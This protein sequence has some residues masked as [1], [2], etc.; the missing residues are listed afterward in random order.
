[1][2]T[3][4]IESLAY[5]RV[6][7]Q[8]LDALTDARRRDVDALVEANRILTEGLG[9]LVRKQLKVRENA[10][11]DVEALVSSVTSGGL[12][13]YIGHQPKVAE[14]WCVKAMMGSRDVAD[15][16]RKLHADACATIYDR[17]VQNLQSMR[18]QARP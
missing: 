14:F 17:F 16:T 15:M 11:S 1:M 12:W 18:T 4:V 2:E 5:A 9:H 8:A 7:S 10:A 13:G 6:P 3:T